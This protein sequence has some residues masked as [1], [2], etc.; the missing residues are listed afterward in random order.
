MWTILQ[1]GLL[2]DW[3]L[4]STIDNVVRSNPRIEFAYV[5]LFQE[6]VLNPRFYKARLPIRAPNGHMMQRNRDVLDSIQNMKMIILN[7]TRAVPVHL[8][9]SWTGR[10]YNFQ[11]D[12]H[13]LENLYRASLL[14]PSHSN[15]VLRLRE[16]AGWYQP[17]ILPV[18]PL[19]R[20][21]FNDCLH[22]Y[23]I[24][25]KVWFGP[26]DLVVRI[27]RDYFHVFSEGR[28]V[29][30]TE[31]ALQRVASHIPVVFGR[32]N[33]SDAALRG[34]GSLCFKKAYL[35]KHSRV[36]FLC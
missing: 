10:R 5:G 36:R 22:W 14:I 2:Y 18:A 30:N 28:G 35:C 33:V 19:H 13:Q 8:P 4:D 25:D 29:K 16:D 27:I 12:Y 21:Q 23:G 9:R 34:D 7:T 3:I 1:T 11:N 17:F 32:I 24:N 31:F 15:N 26:R 6:N 20:L